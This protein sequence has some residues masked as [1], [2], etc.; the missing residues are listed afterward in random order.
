LVRIAAEAVIVLICVDHTLRRSSGADITLVRRARTD[1]GIVHG[2]G[3]W[4]A[5]AL[6]VRRAWAS[7]AGP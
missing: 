4:A 6:N 1:L 3:W 2:R 7:C 5:R